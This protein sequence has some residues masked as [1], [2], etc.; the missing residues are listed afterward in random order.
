VAQLVN[1]TRHGRY[2]VYRG[3]L[4]DVVGAVDIRDLLAVE[5][6]EALIDEQVGELK[7]LPESKRCWELALEMEATGD[8]MALVV[9]EFG[10]VSGLV[11]P[12]DLLAELIG[13]IAEEGEPEP[14]E[15]RRVDL[16]TWILNPF[17]RID[18]VNELTGLGL[19]DGDD[20]QTLAG[21]I[22][23]ELGRIPA[24]RERLRWGD[25]ELEILAA[26]Q[27]RIDLVRLRMGKS[28]R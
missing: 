13:E 26:S 10:A 11:T 7:V 16:H 20:Y 24:A 3:S 28:R 4:D 12:A 25:G 17:L 1:N 8:F 23:T 18:R 2:P 6:R 21:F 14:D 27:R 9:D 19:P 15:C 22:L 5:D